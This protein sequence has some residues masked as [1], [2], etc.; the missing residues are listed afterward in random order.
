MDWALHQPEVRFD[1]RAERAEYERLFRHQA[2][3]LR[4]GLFDSGRWPDQDSIRV[5]GG[6][7]GGIVPTLRQE[8]EEWGTRFHWSFLTRDIPQFLDE[9]AHTLNLVVCD[10]LLRR[11]SRSA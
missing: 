5:K 4:I 1:V 2:R 9:A 7:A 10:A 8:R 6:A 3:V 11:N